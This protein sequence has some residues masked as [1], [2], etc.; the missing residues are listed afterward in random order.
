MD[1]DLVAAFTRVLQES[2][3]VGGN[4]ILPLLERQLQ[5]VASD[6]RIE[7]EGARAKLRELLVDRNMG[8]DG[9]KTR[10]FIEELGEAHFHTLAGR[11]GVELAKLHERPNQKT[12]DYVFSGSTEVCFEVKTPSVA[13]G[14]FRYQREIEDAWQGRLEQQDRLDEGHRIA[15]SELAKA[16]YGDAPGDK[17]LTCA[18]AVLQEKIR[19]NIKSGQFANGPTYLVCSLLALHPYGDMD[20]MLRPVYQRC[21]DTGK[22][23][24]VSGHLWM[25]AFSVPDMLVLSEPAFEG[26]P[27]I[28]GSANGVGILAGDTHDFVQGIVFV[29]YDLQGDSCMCC[30]V[31]CDDQLAEP[32]PTLVGHRWNDRLDSNGWQLGGF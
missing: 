18:V 22:H 7:T 19:G 29:V 1:Y 17:R 2:A 14:E 6:D 13:N 26:E 27:S 11:A 21:H 24:P 31:R 28:E 10:T 9:H 30:L 4:G 20:G 8:L 25:T 5:E 15:F 12:P 23:T 16:P 32:L 3:D